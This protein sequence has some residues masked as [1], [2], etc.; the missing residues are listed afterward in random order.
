MPGRAPVED[1][2]G[3][4]GRPPCAGVSVKRTMRLLRRNVYDDDERYLARG[5]RFG[6]AW[7]S[8]AST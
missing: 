3:V 4:E 5:L 6:R 1:E 8:H 7:L 2:V